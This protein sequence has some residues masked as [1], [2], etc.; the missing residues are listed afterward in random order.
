MTNQIVVLVDLV[1]VRLD[2]VQ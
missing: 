2:I 1:T